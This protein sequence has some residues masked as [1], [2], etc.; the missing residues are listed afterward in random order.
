LI[1]SGEIHARPAGQAK[2][3]TLPFDAECCLPTIDQLNAALGG[4]Y[5]VERLIGEGGMAAVYL[6]SDLRHHRNVAL[7]ILDPD[8]AAVLGEARFLSEIHVTANLG[9]PHL[10]PL[11]DSGAADG[12][13]YYVMPY[14]DGGSLRARLQSEGQLP[15]EDVVTIVAAIAD[16]VDHAHRRGVIHRDLKPENILLLDGQPLVADFGIALAVSKAGGDRLTQSG[17]SL[18]TP[19]YMSPEQATAARL[20]DG[21]SDVFALGAITYEML[22]GEPPYSGATPQAIISRLLTE[23]PRSIRAER[24]SIPRHVEQAVARALEKL[25]ADRW[26]TAGDFARALAAEAPPKQEETT[27]VASR[28]ARIRELSAWTLAAAAVMSAFYLATYRATD[29]VA[30]AAPAPRAIKLAV[31][32]PESVSVSGVSAQVVAISPNGTQLAILGVRGG[33]RRIYL[34][35]LDDPEIRAVRG[36]EGAS[37]HSFTADGRSL[38]FNAH[39]ALYVLPTLGGVPRKLADSV[40]GPA[41]SGAN[42]EVLYQFRQGLWLTSE[43]G[44]VRRMLVGPDSAHGID[45]IVHPEVLPGDQYALATIVTS[46]PDADQLAL[47]SMRDGS[48]TRLGLSGKS[49]HYL[50]SGHLMIAREGG[51]AYVVPFS[52]RRREPTGPPVLLLDGIREASGNSGVSSL[53]VSS[54][55][56]LAYATPLEGPQAMYVVDLKGG[57][58]QLNATPRSFGSPRISPDG[59]K[60]LLRIATPNGGGWWLYEKETGRLTRLTGDTS[61]GPGDWTRDGNHFVY[62]EGARTSAERLVKRAWDGSGNAE[63]LTPPRQPYDYSS[64]SIGPSNGLSAFTRGPGAVS[65]IWVAPTDRLTEERPLITAEGSRTTPRVSPSGR[66]LAYTSDESGKA[67]VYVTPL[68]DN[69]RKVL[70]SVD[71]GTDPK[72]S[73]DGQFVFYRGQTRLMRARIIEEPLTIGGLDTLLTTN[74]SYSTY[75]VFP[76]GELL[77]LRGV[78]THS[79]VYVLTNWQQLRTRMGAVT[80]EPY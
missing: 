10:L 48:V 74:A 41:T 2:W 4:R 13:L 8:L 23:K 30:R 39:N 62:V 11:F 68:S 58:R 56:I 59:K 22:T 43:Q 31:E 45:Q 3:T 76:S 49:A 67:E 19:Q 71:G 50:A 75:D 63:P 47:V 66:L 7:K 6:A 35:D 51:V 36:S 12:S 18:G 70:V 57:E 55:G 44:G 5:T 64:V 33:E 17:I 40:I 73:R 29:Q 20:V 28:R 72:W 27:S 37:Y 78:N 61:I 42:G 16:A 24:P 77:I 14:V 65:A 46:G 1:D 25:P 54:G 52:L 15:L 21:R 9:H 69:G 26:A 32:L 60:I 34:R 80:A 38:L 53:A 79:S